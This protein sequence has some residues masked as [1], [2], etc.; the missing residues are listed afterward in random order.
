MDLTILQLNAQGSK[1]VA[2]DLRK[3]TE[4]LIDIIVLQEPYSLDGRVKG[5]TGI[6]GRVLQPRGPA[7]KSAIIINNS[8]I[9]ILQLY[10]EESNHIVAV[11]IKF[12]SEKFY[13][14]S[15]YFQFS[16]S[17]EPYL[18]S[19]DEYI[20]KIRDCNANN[21]IVICA[22]VN[23]LSTSWFSRTTNE[24]G[25]KI[26]EFIMANLIVLNQASRY[27]T[28]SSH[29]GGDYLYIFFID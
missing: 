13:L 3:H 1:E 23:A 17:V 26:E 29:S 2:S 28:Y 22:D 6:R 15:A 19:L 14:I 25:D 5:Y 27:T 20:G 8:N 12:E 21:E 7:P 11:Q 9:D 16:H 10:V 24:T 18:S 4:N